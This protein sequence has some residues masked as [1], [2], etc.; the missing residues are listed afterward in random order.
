MHSLLYLL[1]PVT[2]GE[3]VSMYTT[4]LQQ[5]FVSCNPLLNLAA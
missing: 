2:V 4:H 1:Q 3:A 5:A